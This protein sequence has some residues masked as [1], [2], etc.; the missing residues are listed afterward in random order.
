MSGSLSRRSFIAAALATPAALAAGCG[1]GSSNS[2]GHSSQSKNVARSWTDMTHA[3]VIANR[4][5][6]PASARAH[7][8][9]STGMFDAW[10]AYDALAVGTQLGG[11]LRRPAAERTTANKQKAVSFAAYRALVDLFPSQK[12][13][14]D[15]NMTSLGYDPTDVSMDVTTASGIGN[16]VAAALLTYRHSDGSN[17]LGDLHTGAYSDYTGYKAKNP[18]DTNNPSTNIV[19]DPDHWQPLTVSNGS[20][21]FVVQSFAGASW[22]Q[23][24]PF[25]LTASYQFRRT[26]VL[27][28][29]GSPEFTAKCQ[30]VIDRSATLTEAEKLNTEYWAD[31][32]GSVSPPGHMMILAD[33]V[34]TRD[35]HDLD[36]DVKFFF[37]VSN[38]VFDAGIACWDT[39]RAY[40]SIRPLT[41]IHLAFKGK[42]I[43]AWGGPGVGTVSLLGEAFGTYQSP[44]FVTP[45]FPSFSSG[46]ST[47]TSAACEVMKQFTQSDNFG[48]QVTFAQGSSLLEP[49]IVPSK[50]L[51]VTYPTFTG[52]P[53]TVADSRVTGGIHFTEDNTAGIEMGKQVAQVVYTKVQ[54]YING[55]A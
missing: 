49:G 34:S 23:V 38:A 52:T 18:P 32:P 55:T 5:N 11:S 8:I 47:F 1:G 35:N 27:S 36:T 50:S 20:G 19:T 37:L 24:K 7:A 41:A 3:G 44:T 10:S 21:G 46:H 13:A 43:Q 4:I 48:F 54:T 31:G 26:E 45:A 22:Y 30:A 12:T 33:Y 16:K 53:L 6:P 39:K 29:F 42:T 15:A 40:E 25:S 17:Q 51:T 2:G 14:I 28:K 9:V